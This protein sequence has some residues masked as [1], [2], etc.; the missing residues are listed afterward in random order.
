MCDEDET[1]DVNK[2]KVSLSLVWKFL[3]RAGGQAIS[4]LLGIILA[5][6]LTPTEYGLVALITI[7]ISIATVFVQGG[8]NTALIQRQDTNNSDY[9]SILWFT[10]FV[11]T[12]LYAILYLTAPLIA[13]YFNNVDLIPIVRVLS[14]ILLPGALNSVQVA[15]ETKK[16]QFRN[17]FYASAVSAILSGIIGVALAYC[18]YGAWAIVFQQL[19]NQIINC[20]VLLLISEWK[21]RLQ[22][23]HTSVKRMIPFGSKVLA[24]NLLVTVFLNIRS[25]IIGRVYN[26]ES[27][28]YFNRGKT[29]PSTLMDTV[30]GTIQSVLLP[31]YSSLQN[32]KIRL[33]NVLR[34]SISLGCYVLFP[35]LLGL[36]AVADP[37]IKLLLTEKWTSAIV[38]VQIFAV[39]Y[40]FQP[41]QIASAQALKAIG[42]SDVTLKIEVYRKI[43]EII[44]LLISI[45]FG[46]EAIAWSTVAAGFIACLI[47]APLCKRYL[48]YSY[49]E[50][51]VDLIPSFALSV[52]MFIIVTNVIQLFNVGY[53]GQLSFGIIIGI[54]VYI[55]LSKIIG[56]KSLTYIINTFRKPT[57]R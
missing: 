4:F 47:S 28:A 39:G 43:T 14:L 21:P 49:S 38:Y 54:A 42:R 37:F 20:I 8:F 17:L 16:M 30:D 29:F 44:C 22:Y 35:C 51:L 5:R 18:K 13:K 50:Q 7:F 33:K 55:L 10:L 46:V 1:M 52:I 53:F 41:I 27:L 25:L 9:N 3:E 11:S 56:N 57:K 40:M 34:Q 19:T 32:N 48:E 23:E 15:F 45:Q 24:S 31:T 36:A 12:V 6:L 2:K 26:A